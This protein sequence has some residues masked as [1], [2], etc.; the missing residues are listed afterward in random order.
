M[1]HV[2]HTHSQFCLP[3]MTLLYTGLVSLVLDLHIVHESWG[4]N[5]DP[6]T[7]GH[8]HYPKDLERSL[9]ETTPDKI[10]SYRSDYNDRPSNSMSFMPVI[11][12]TSGRIHRE[13]VSSFFTSSSG[14]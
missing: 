1:V 10:Q 7:H 5:S 3:K 8:L 4:S 12:S 9:N 6:T 2:V 13:F 14:N 11:A